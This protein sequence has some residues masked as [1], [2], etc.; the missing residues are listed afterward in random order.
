LVLN[1]RAA[2]AAV[3]AN[4]DYVTGN[5][6]VPRVARHSEP[7]DRGL[8]QP[9]AFSLDFWWLYLFYLGLLTRVMVALVLGAFALWVVMC[10]QGLGG[11]LA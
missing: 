9:L 3:P 8:S 4:F 6:P 10:C 2:L 5:R 1:T 7:D 11:E